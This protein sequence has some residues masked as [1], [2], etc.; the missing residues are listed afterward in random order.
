MTW[1]E[2]I[3]QWLAREERSQSQLA[4]WAK[5]DV[6]Y[7]SA[8]LNGLRQPGTKVL[9]RLDQAMGLPVGTLEG[10]RSQTQLPIEEVATDGH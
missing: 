5:M 6:S 3:R 1:Q 7:L 9:G 2:A 4:R 8:I 10:L